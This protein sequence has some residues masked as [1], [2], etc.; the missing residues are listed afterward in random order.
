MEFARAFI[1][2]YAHYLGQLWAAVLIGF[3]LSG[4]LNE[5]LP[6][7]II[8]RYLGA[9]GLKPILISSCIG[10]VL[11]VCCFG[12]LPIAMTLRRRGACLGPVLAFLVAAPATSV[13]ALIV[14]W[15]LLGSLFTVYIFCGVLALGVIIGTLGNFFSTA[16][17]PRIGGGRECC[18]ASGEQHGECG[19]KTG[20]K[21]RSAIRYAFITLPKEIGVELL[22]GVAA[23]SFILV[24]PPIQNFI[25]RF[26]SGGIGYGFSL[27][28]GLGT[29]VCSTASVPLTHAFLK[30]GMGHGPAMTY[31]IIGPITS[32]GSLLI[33][34][35]SFGGRVLLFYLVSVGL[36][37]VVLGIGFNG[38]VAARHA[39]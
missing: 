26:L 20:I 13:S 30:S 27:V 19:T 3:L 18:H 2:T 38:I 37:A 10:M 4:L 33:L 14:C 17:K 11:P 32:Y 34:H 9:R 39:W 36:L 1:E 12:S 29:Y 5:F 22:V 6:A 28:V 35:K 15:R 8:E 16:L 25:E 23:A 24:F 31:L 21:I 7:H